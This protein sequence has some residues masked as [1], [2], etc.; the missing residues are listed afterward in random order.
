MDLLENEA[1]KGENKSNLT[2]FV[3][4]FVIIAI[5]AA[6]CCYLNYTF[7]TLLA[8]AVFIMFIC[9]FFG[10]IIVSRPILILLIALFKYCKFKRRGY[11]K[12][13]YKSPQELRQV[14]NKAIKDM[15]D[16]RK[17]MRE[18]M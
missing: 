5:A 12:V 10:D 1:F 18:N 7:Q 13:Q 4:L 6:F 14:F 2:T 3:V 8:Q 11:E 15:F 9:S 16:S 17:K